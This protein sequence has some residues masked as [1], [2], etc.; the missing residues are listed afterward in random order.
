MLVIASIL[1]GC[2]T[3]TGVLPSGEKG[4]YLVSQQHHTIY[5]T[6]YTV[7]QATINE[8]SDFCERRDQDFELL[9]AESTLSARERHPAALVRFQCVERRHLIQFGEP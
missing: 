2:A 4:T 5:S 3:S 8:A 9:G 1:G 7:Q 6:L